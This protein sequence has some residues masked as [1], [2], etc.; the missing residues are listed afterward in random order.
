MKKAW[1]LLLLLFFIRAAQSAPADSVQVKKKY[2]TKQLSGSLINLDGVPDE[3]AW[4]AVE[5]GGDFTQYQPNGGKPPSQKTNFKVL[6]D[7]K[8][9]YIAYRCLDAAPDSIIKRMGRR[10]EF[11][12][13]WIEINIDSYHDQRTAFSFNLS[14]S[15]VRSDEFVSNNGNNWDASWNPIWFAKTHVNSEGWSGEVKI[16]FSQL[17][18]GNEPEKVWGLQIIRRLFRK[19]E[20]STWQNIP[21]NA[22]VWV[23]AFG[24][25]HGLHG[26]PMHRQVEIAPYV[27]AQ[28]DRYKKEEGNPFAKGSDSKMNA[29][30]DGKFAITNDLILDFTINPDFGQVEADPSQVRID[31]FQNFFE[32]RRPFFI[33][34]RNIFDY[35]LT[36]SEAGGDYDS[37]LLFYSRRI[38][39]SPHGNPEINDD[40]YL[41]SPQNTSILGALKFSG[42]TKKGW[43]IGVLESITQ[44]E[45]ATIDHDG[46]RREELIEPLTHY[47]VGRLQKDIK[48]GNTILGGIITGV[49][50]EK[51]L[52]DQLH[53]N[54]Y[55]GGLDFVQYWKER[56]WYIRGNVVFSQVQGTKEAILNTQTSFEHVFQRPDAREVAVDSNRTSLA[57]MGGTFRFGKIGGKTGKLGQVFRF[58]T[59]VTLRSPGLELNDLGFMLTANEINHFTWAGLHYQKPFSIFRN[60][61]LNYNH[62]ARWDYGGQFLYQAFNFNSHATF[63]NYWQSG[64]GLTW[65][66]FDI[67]NNALRG[68]SSIRRPPGLGNFFYVISDMRKKFYV[69]LETFNFWG[70]S[71]T[72]KGNNIDLTTTF[73]PINALRISLTG[74]YS[75][76]WRRQDQ[77]VSEVTS[78]NQTRT[79]VGRVAQKTLR[80]TGRISYN[81][82]PDLTVQYYGQ[83]YITRPVYDNFAYVS[84]PLARKYDQR[85]Q[86]VDRSQ[87]SL[88][89]DEY[90]IDENQDGTPDYSFTKPDFNFVQF[91]SNLV[92]RWEYRAGSELYLVWSQ[93]NTPDA[94]ADINT[95]LA[96]SL[97]KNAFAEQSRNIFLIKW[98]YRFLR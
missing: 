24:E 63:K 52:S 25:L 44:R 59:G 72:V 96:N 8:F 93:G 15:G 22:G 10:D 68:A 82:T 69:T 26:I 12:G 80:F 5:W 41:K 23:S 53:R 9:L 87:M 45:I 57:G 1:L 2:V 55:S 38:G 81:I 48:A 60:A 37:D 51:G 56:T 92:A 17:R 76:N 66:T 4:K 39:S 6:Y 65:N 30:V 75:Y 21:Q 33:E 73:Q 32:E 18:Y 28:T 94:N 35:R 31:G 46:Q 71:N 86:L 67:S 42:K 61:R 54:A 77:Y 90:K 19:E 43:S 79:I 20:R 36:G 84:K 88:S 14:V 64:M 97:W 91:R 62:W 83:P 70:F 89:N 47:F 40:E 16:P 58:E 7:T 50:R 34:S 85:F 3:E 78:N 74:S 27:T 98:T 49:N 13:D 11:P 95:P 29:G